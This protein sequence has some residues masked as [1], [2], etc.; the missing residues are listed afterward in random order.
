MIYIEA[1]VG[2]GYSEADEEDMEVINDDTTSRKRAQ[3]YNT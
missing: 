2:V 3:K 1:P